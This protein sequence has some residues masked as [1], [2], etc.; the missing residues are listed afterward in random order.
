M[1]NK[2]IA[3]YSLITDV[4]TGDYLPIWD[5]SLGITCKVYV[6]DVSNATG[7]SPVNNHFL[8]IMVDRYAWISG[9]IGGQTGSHILSGQYG[10]ILAGVSNV[11][12]GRQCVVVG[13][14]TN[15]AKGFASF[16]GAGSANQATGDWSFIGAGRSNLVDDIESSIVGGDNNIVNEKLC[17]IGGGGSNVVFTD[18]NIGQSSIVGGN[19]NKVSA[20]YAFVGGGQGNLESGN[21]SSIVGGDS[22]RVTGN[23]SIIGGGQR[24]TSSGINSFIGGGT[25]NIVYSEKVAIVGGNANLGSGIY[26]FIGG[27]NTN[28]TDGTSSSVVGGNTNVAKGI[29]CFVGGGNSNQVRSDQSLGNSSIVGG[30]NNQVIGAYAAILGGDINK[31]T[32]TN[33]VVIGGSSNV[34]SGNYSFTMGTKC[35]AFQ[36]GAVMFG[37]STDVVKRSYGQD[38]FTANYSGGVWITGGGL[39]ARRG[40]NLYPTGVTPSAS[41]GG[42]SGDFAYKD[43]YL[44]VFT[45]DNAD[46][47]NK[48]WGR[49]QLSTLNNTP[50]SVVTNIASQ[51]EGVGT[52]YTLTETWAKVDFGTTDVDQTLNAAGTWLIMGEVQFSG[53]GESNHV[54]YQLYNSSDIAS[55]PGTTRTQY[56]GTN[57]D[58]VSP[59]STVITT[60]AAKTIQLYSRL[61]NAAGAEP[62]IIVS[63]KTKLLQIRLF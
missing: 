2:N 58:I 61:A 11:V 4:N 3:Q 40:F 41:V 48:N 47:S 46:L 32:G 52:N 39:N 8:D 19:S 59:I 63:D 20:Y 51:T 9:V 26:S 1:A 5:S 57:T 38:S 36:N 56:V 54:D 34:S 62:P 18:N 31:V 7:N 16:V 13:G 60:T 42:R 27:G 50:P 17:F 49:V 22:N 35:E 55:V 25:D 14:N 43:D 29:Y 33:A 53:R 15:T 30:E 6:N 21:W 24:N 37:D 23:Y 45:G 44:Y 12:S 28:T 10:G